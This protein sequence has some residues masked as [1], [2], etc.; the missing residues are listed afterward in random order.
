MKKIAIITLGLLLLSGQASAYV[1]WMTN[2]IESKAIGVNDFTYVSLFIYDENSV[3]LTWLTPTIKATPDY[4]VVIWDVFDCTTAEWRE[5]CIN[6]DPDLGWLRW[7]YV[8]KIASKNVEE[9]V[10]LTVLSSSIADE[11]PKMWVLDLKIGKWWEAIKKVETLSEVPK[12]WTDNIK[13][14][15]FLYMALWLLV[16]LVGWM[17]MFNRKE[18]HIGK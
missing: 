8:A 13:G 17:F 9:D 10:K 7:S 2:K 4:P 18:A 5:E 14:T 15:Y 3:P 12:V 6:V 1:N 11:T 16:M